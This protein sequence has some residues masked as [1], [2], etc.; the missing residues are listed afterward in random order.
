MRYETSYILFL[1]R[2]MHFPKAGS[3]SWLKTRQQ[4]SF[5]SIVLSKLFLLLLYMYSQNLSCNLFS[6]IPVLYLCSY[7][8]VL[9][10]TSPVSSV[11]KVFFLLFG[12]FIFMTSQNTCSNFCSIS[13]HLEIK[14]YTIEI[15]EIYLSREDSH[16]FRW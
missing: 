4:L 1:Y 3:I 13:L 16:L 7:F 12:K 5:A 11:K 8:A 14:Y 15:S 9:F 6:T 10:Y 2:E